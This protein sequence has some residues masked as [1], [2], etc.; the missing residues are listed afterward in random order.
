MQQLRI[1]TLT[2]PR[3]RGT[4]APRPP[5]DIVVQPVP[6]L[7]AT[8]FFGAYTLISLLRF[9][10]VENPSWDLA[11]FEQAVKGYA[12]LGA[13][14]VDVRQP[15]MN[16]L[17][18]HF[19]PIL[20]TLAPLYRVFPSPVT[21]LLVQAL[22]FAVSVVPVTRIAMRFHGEARGAAIGL[23]YGLSWGIQRAVE[24]DFH[25]IAFAVPLIAFTLEKLLLRR[26]LAA[27]LWCLPLLL[28]KEDLALTVGAVG[29]YLLIQRKW[30][31]GAAMM[32]AG[33]AAMAL[34]V[35]VLIP[36]L[37]PDGVYDQGKSAGGG[38][39]FGIFGGFP[40]DLVWPFI[41]VKTLIW[42]FGA[43]GFLALRSPVAVVA[44]PTL[45]WRLLSD[46]P[47]HWG[48]DWHY[49]AVLMP[50]VFVALVD[51]IKRAGESPRP[52]LRT[53]AR[54]LPAAVV[55]A[56]LALCAFL[57]ASRLIEPDEYK[58]PPRLPAANAAVHKVAEGSTVET[59]LGLISQLPSR[60]R[61]FW[62][63]ATG[64]VVPDYIAVNQPEEWDQE[65]RERLV[66]EA[67]DRH[68]GAVY[69]IVF[70]NKFVILQHVP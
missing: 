40:Q 28:V 55:G 13:P 34:T 22:L 32:V 50:I 60:A 23:A 9:R 31:P 47:N 33:A 24:F 6:Y 37:N 12:H 62:I 48:Q 42:V 27:I 53:Y 61:V 7:L 39:L 66:Q 68:N 41:K 49:N 10:K 58:T 19:S 14:I 70:A 4:D 59:D 15:G 57:P 38:S 43:V 36:A 52:W 65:A 25:E 51:G 2:I 1:G 18:D 67:A 69:E 26:W 5:R 16:Q 8:M 17:G 30:W 56:S 54:N 29:I 20:A 46:T 3:Q 21:L 64:G 45:A 63:G 44:A 35:Y 11:I